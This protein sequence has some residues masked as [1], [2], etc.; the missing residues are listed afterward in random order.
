[1]S[2]VPFTQKP[3][4]ALK[5]ILAVVLGIVFGVTFKTNP[6]LFGIKNEDLGQLGMLFIKF[7]RALATPLVFLAIIESF[8]KMSFTLKQGVKFVSICLVNSLVAMTI[9]LTLLNTLEPGKRWA[10]KIQEMKVALGTGE[11][12]HKKA[13]AKAD[14]PEAPQASFS[15]LQNLSY[16]VPSGLLRPFFYNN[17][18]S[19]VLISLL[20]GAAFR[21]LLD[22]PHAPLMVAGIEFLFEW[23]QKMLA[24]IIH[25][26]PYGVFGV[27]AQVVGAVGVGVFHFLWIFLAVILGGFFLH[28]LIYYP[29]VVWL[30]GK[31]SPRIFLGQGMDAIMT[32][33][34]INS[35]LGTVPI[36]LD[37]LTKRMGVSPAS[38]RFAACI[39]TNLNNDGITL[40]EAM[41]AIFL[42]QAVGMSL[43]IGQQLTI[44][45][46]SLLAGAGI[47]GIPEAGLIV[48]P[49]VLSA[50]GLPEGVVLTAIPLV[51][52]VDWIIARCR[53]GVNVMS[54]M[55]VAI[56]L[57]RFESTD[58]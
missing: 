55:T 46:A 25:F 52:P 34:S 1:M 2:F 58:N 7:L 19:I 17:I 35:S 30:V 51:L 40:Y 36:T 13:P 24:I 28:A 53:S 9:G 22:H 20:A 23:L 31:K 48:L 42:A 57:D 44:V 27:V 10:G 4:L 50:A 37:C 29:L 14:D 21:Q 11:K 6:I 16:Y 45:V 54:D 26:I 39:G 38:A 41:T 5:V 18:I 47:A 49:L 3:P 32:G 56:L 33:L 8:T 43:G 12:E 15:F